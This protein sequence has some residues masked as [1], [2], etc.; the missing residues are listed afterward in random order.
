MRIENVVEFNASMGCLDGYSF[1]DEKCVKHGATGAKFIVLAVS[2]A[3]FKIFWVNDCL[4]A[5]EIMAL[6]THQVQGPYAT[7]P[8]RHVS[9][10]KGI[11]L[12]RFVSALH[13]V[14]KT[15]RQESNISWQTRE[16][17][18]IY[19]LG[20]TLR[21]M[22]DYG[23]A[24][25]MVLPVAR[26]GVSDMAPKGLTMLLGCDTYA[27][28]LVSLPRREFTFLISSDPS[29]PDKDVG[30]F[31]N[32]PISRDLRHFTGDFGFI[33]Q[34]L[35]LTR[36][37]FYII[38]RRVRDLGACSAGRAR[39]GGTFSVEE[40]DGEQRVLGRAL[41]GV[42]PSFKLRLTK[43]STFYPSSKSSF[44]FSKRSWYNGN[45][46]V[47]I[48]RCQ[49]LGED[50]DSDHFKMWDQHL[51]CLAGGFLKSEAASL[52]WQEP[53]VG[54]CFLAPLGPY[55]GMLGAKP[56]GIRRGGLEIAM[57]AWRAFFGK[58]CTLGG[59]ELDWSSK[60]WLLK[61]L[62]RLELYCSLAAEWC[63]S[64]PEAIA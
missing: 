30:L 34:V 58:T 23:F 50:V 3:L 16:Q 19:A 39:A 33:S 37:P 56:K 32:D 35:Y 42:L 60:L 55:T 29:W 26:R 36:H 14:V 46:V 47:Q 44:R 11:E 17:R 53:S 28:C 61:E 15:D 27:W 64:P 43:S 24:G 4:L 45:M 57:E 9:W 48:P 63:S 7:F 38:W 6:V 54:W 51:H 2:G 21:G 22:K 12:K 31:G 20:G 52:V 40:E 62:W 13:V 5:V 59:G 49:F 18:I 25:V 41:R 8:S 10:N 1:G